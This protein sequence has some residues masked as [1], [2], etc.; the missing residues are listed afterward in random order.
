M[1]DIGNELLRIR[2]QAE[3]ALSAIHVFGYAAGFLNYM[4]TV[5]DEQELGVMG[6]NILNGMECLTDYMKK[7][8]RGIDG[9]AEKVGM[10]EG[11]D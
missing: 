7:I 9:L 11:K 2:E 5:T 1:E 4:S 3:T 10:E 8:I 6:N